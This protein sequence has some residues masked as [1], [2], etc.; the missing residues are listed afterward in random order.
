MTSGVTVRVV[1]IA[2]TSLCS[3]RNRRCVGWLL[4]FLST[5]L[6]KHVTMR[7]TISI[8]YY[9]I[10]I[11]RFSP[12]IFP[13]AFCISCD[14]LIPT[15]ENFRV[16]PFIDHALMLKFLLLLNR[17]RVLFGWQFLSCSTIQ[18]HLHARTKLSFRLISPLLNFSYCIDI[19]IGTNRYEKNRFFS[20]STR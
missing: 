5:I 1:P 15:L 7:R 13:K 4:Q 6:E 16:W 11:S 20:S 12:W 10:I 17:M 3:G 8:I 9:Q 18:D 14:T 19:D 2:S